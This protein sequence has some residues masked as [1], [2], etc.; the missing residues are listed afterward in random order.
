M[1]PRA[2]HGRVACRPLRP[3]ASGRPSSE[4]RML[5]SDIDHRFQRLSSRSV[6]V[7]S[8]GDRGP[9]AIAVHM[10]DVH[11]LKFDY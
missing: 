7:L 10:Y 2:G 6:C 8:R 3:F 4:I 11:P 1:L 9:T 5:S